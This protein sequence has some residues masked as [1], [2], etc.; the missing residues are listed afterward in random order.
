MFYLGFNVRK[1][2]MSIREFRQAVAIMI[3]KEFVTQTVL[4]GA[5]IPAYSMVPSGNAAW[6]N[7]N[8]PSLGQGLDRGER[9]LQ[10]VELLKSAGF[11]YE[12]E[13]EMRRRRQLRRQ[14]RQGS[15]NARRAPTCQR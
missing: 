8:T 14:G 7:A 11:T 15:E 13:P 2:P 9:L 5:A 1:E 4:Q 12:E 3:D 10:A 6:F